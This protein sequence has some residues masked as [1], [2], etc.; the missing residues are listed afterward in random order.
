MKKLLLILCFAALFTSC[1]TEQKPQPERLL[2]SDLVLSFFA[3]LLLPKNE[4][5]LANH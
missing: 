2:N 3:T 5:S 4:K 1:K